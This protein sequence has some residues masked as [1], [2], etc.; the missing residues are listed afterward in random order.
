M[1]DLPEGWAEV[2]LD[3]LAEV[4]LGRQRSP[5][6]ATGPNMR[7]YVRAANVKWSGI[8]VADVKEMDFTPR[9][10]DTYRLQRGDL[11]LNEASGSASEV[12][13][14]ALWGEEI[15]D[16]CFQN[17]LIRVR[18]PAEFVPFLYTHFRADAVTGRFGR[19]SRGVGIHHL[20]KGTLAD[21]DIRVPPIEEQRRIVE[22]I[23]AVNERST[24]AREALERLP[25]LL[26]R[27]R[28]SV[29]AAAFRGD[30]TAE[31]RAQNPDVESA[32]ALLERIRK[33]RRRRW[34]EDY[35]AKQRAKGK[36][37]ENDNWK[38]NY[39]EP[40][41]YDPSTPPQ[42]P[43]GWALVSLDALTS[44]VTS[45]SRAW[46]KHYGRGTGTFIMAQNV[47]PLR[48]DLGFRQAVDPPKDD[49]DCRRSQVE[50]GDL[51]ATI[52]GANAGDVCRVATALP[53]HYV[54][55]SVALLRP[56]VPVMAEFIEFYLNSEQD[57]RAQWNHY[58]YGQGRPHLSFDQIRMTV[59]PLPPLDEQE[60]IVERVHERL[61]RLP[62][63][64][65]ALPPILSRLER[66]EQ[67]ILANAFRG[68]LV[69]QDSNDEPAC[70]LL[71]RIRAEREAAAPKKRG[72]S[73]KK[74]SASKKGE[75]K[76]L[77]RS[78]PDDNG[79]GSNGAPS[80]ETVLALLKK[81]ALHR[82]AKAH[83]VE[84]TDRRS[85]AGALGPITD[86]A[87]DLA[88][89][90]EP[91]KGAE[92]KEICGALGLSRSGNKA[93]LRAAILSK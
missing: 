11:L 80:V 2:K 63:L 88:A 37:P 1:T 36:K 27:F 75:P 17:T 24:R 74:R 47:R 35:L 90:L 51:L 59:V 8:D 69:P 78:D 38:A 54:C 40:V 77:Q 55:Q 81:D 26:E 25:P 15:P 10:F 68:E 52:V 28:Q 7:S 73:K 85:V 29:L 3:E 70:V 19:A 82:I 92:L 65:G 50:P 66:L 83:D 9:E 31:W 62:G 5:K 84:L 21:W 18:A 13:K 89:L 64:E 44:V 53:E 56:V 58:M 61:A 87:L 91:L 42:V 33:E 4:R 71:E 22:K 67:S 12:G 79:A 60:Q 93:R 41:A 34:E 16:C 76:K 49:S 46:K 48:L 72:R 43:E 86:A 57:G 45:G 20:S 30:L 6:R 14:P 23:G 32:S 39:K